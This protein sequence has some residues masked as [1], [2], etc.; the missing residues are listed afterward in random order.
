MTRDFYETVI[1]NAETLGELRIIHRFL[2][3][4]FSITGTELKSVS[5]YIAN[6]EAN[7]L[8]DMETSS[9]PDRGGLNAV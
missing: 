3:C 8:L 4:D 1:A 5:A 6:R 9:L 7:I 2:V